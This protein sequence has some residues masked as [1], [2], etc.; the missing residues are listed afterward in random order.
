M[1]NNNPKLKM[2][3]LVLWNKEEQIKDLHNDKRFQL[4]LSGDKIIYNG[5]GPYSRQ[6]PYNRKIQPNE[7][8]SLDN[9][10]KTLNLKIVDYRVPEK[11][12]RIGIIGASGSKC[13][14]FVTVQNYEDLLERVE[15][16]IRTI[17][18][19]L[20]NVILTS[21]GAAFCDHLAVKLFGMYPDEFKGLELYLPCE[22]DDDRCEFLDNNSSDW[23]T[24]PGKL[25]NKLHKQFSQK[26]DIDS[27]NEIAE[28]KEAYPDKVSFDV[29]KGFHTRNTKIAKSDYLIACTPGKNEPRDGGTADTWKKCKNIKYHI[30]IKSD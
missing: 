18:P 21:G 29:S 6:A 1:S 8:K 19:D 20:S 24:N 11:V 2:T 4:Y 10:A 3:Q 23:R 27:L 22:Y 16:Q 14:T 12:L 13:P 28:I 17:S 26:I 25:A 30:T 15:L 7:N 5:Q 9:I